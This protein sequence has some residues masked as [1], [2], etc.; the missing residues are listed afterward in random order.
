MQLPFEPAGGHHAQPRGPQ[1]DSWSTFESPAI[2]LQRRAPAAETV[3][4]SDSCWQEE[5]R[6]RLDAVEGAPGDAD[7]D[8]LMARAAACMA[9]HPEPGDA[10]AALVK[11]AVYALSRVGLGR[12]VAATEWL[13]AVAVGPQRETWGAAA[14]ATAREHLANPACRTRL[15]PLM[16]DERCGRGARLLL[17]REAGAAGLPV[18]AELVPTTSWGG[19][20][21]LRDT[22]TA[23]LGLL[24]QPLGPPTLAA[25]Y[26][27]A[28]WLQRRLLLAEVGAPGHAPAVPLLVRLGQR[29]DPTTRRAVVEALDRIGDPAVEPFLV[30]AL[31]DPDHSL[32]RLAAAVLGR[33]GTPAALRPLRALAAAAPGD[34]R[35]A[36]AAATDAILTRHP[37][38][39]AT[40]G[41]LALAAEGAGALSLSEDVR[42]RYEAVA[43]VLRETPRPP[44]G[45][46]ARWSRVAHPPR[47]V[48]PW[49][50]P[51][52]VMRGAG[53]YTWMPWILLA[54]AAIG[55]LLTGEH[56][57]TRIGVMLGGL[58]LLVAIP[59]GGLVAQREWRL[60]R[61]GVATLGELE[62][63]N[64]RETRKRVRGSTITNTW[65]D[66]RFRYLADDGQ[67][68]TTT[69]RLL[70]RER[71]L[72]DEH[73]EPLLHDPERGDV[74][75]FDELVSLR[76]DDHGS[77]R[78]RWGLRS[79]VGALLPPVALLTAA[80]MAF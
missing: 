63:M 51:D 32:Q 52:R 66:Y 77:L 8:W 33:L 69:V 28:S 49:F 31:D 20:G 15:L 74:L 1:C 61:H 70:Q 62:A 73:L 76:V 38:L 29:A 22:Q 30:A 42:A 79:T 53:A 58:W 65:Y 55:H 36:A 3:Q 2:A 50:W 60:L 71:A 59:V 35:R 16:H 26:D 37:A 7:A 6:A 75:P 45:D 57:L 56:E 11:R 27:K 14:I 5:D 40:A 72:E 46:V 48:P 9:H 47:R 12:R 68:R 44:P 25:L 80:A 21:A 64:R 43:D 13:A 41:G 17:A 34:V 4:V 54:G 24:D 78:Y 10:E 19:M 39:A 67:F 23:L 18:L